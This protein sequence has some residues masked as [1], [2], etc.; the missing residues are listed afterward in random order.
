MSNVIT[1]NTQENRIIVMNLAISALAI[2]R[3]IDLASLGIKVEELPEATKK[4]L[5]EKIFPQEFLRGYSLL[6]EHADL[7]VN[8]V[9]STRTELGVITSF[10]E[11]IEIVKVLKELQT[12]WGKRKELDAPR[13]DSMC[14]EHLLA[15]SQAAIK[16]GA[17]ASQVNILV[18][19]IQK[20]QPSWAEVESKLTFKYSVTPVTLD[21]DEFD[22]ELFEAQRDSVVAMREGVLGSLLQFVC[23]EAKEMLERLEAQEKKKG[24][25]GLRVNPRTVARARVMQAKLKSLGF[26]HPLLRPLHT[27]ISTILDKVD[28]TEALIGR[29]YLTFKELCTALR[30]QT[31]VHERLLKGIP[32][33]SIASQ[34]TVIAT[35]AVAAASVAIAAAPVATQPSVTAPAAKAKKAAAGSAVA[36]AATQPVAAP[37]VKPASQQAVMTGLFL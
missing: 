1:A 30:D 11:A 3:Q 33:I 14:A 28:D 18:T 16:A 37:V 10:S 9:G 35:A 24:T 27:E 8:G 15:I 29:D 34:A 4:M 26:I 20:K 36:P 19:A 7:A 22:A 13:F 31:L 32:L 6:R 25:I 17:D 12:K 5:R 23:A 2:E 21:E